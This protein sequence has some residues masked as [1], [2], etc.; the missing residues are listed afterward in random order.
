VSLKQIILLLHFNFEINYE[1]SRCVNDTSRQGFG[2]T[3][4]NKSFACV[5]A[6]L[7]IFHNLETSI[8]SLFFS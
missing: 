7:S 5:I 1:F 3:D 8:T 6:R 4:K 2:N